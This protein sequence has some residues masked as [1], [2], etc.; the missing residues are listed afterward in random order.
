VQ[1]VLTCAA[2]AAAAAADSKDVAARNMCWRTIRAVTL[3]KSPKAA[4]HAAVL[5]GNRLKEE[6]W[7][8]LECTARELRS[9]LRDGNDQVG[10]HGGMSRSLAAANVLALGALSVCGEASQGTGISGRRA[11]QHGVHA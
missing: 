2:A 7:A 10:A 3:C 9:S 1:H 4:S 11:A 5:S 6:L 8:T